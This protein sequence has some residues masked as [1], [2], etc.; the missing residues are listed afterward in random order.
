[1]A[2]RAIFRP[3]LAACPCRQG[4]YDVESTPPTAFSGSRRKRRTRRSGWG[5]AI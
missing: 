1:M 4:L 5:A 3:G 2:G